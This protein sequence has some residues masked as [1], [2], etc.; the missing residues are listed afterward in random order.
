M[1]GRYAQTTSREALA[2]LLD[3]IPTVE[4][5]PR[6]NISPTQLCPVVVMEEGERRLALQRWGLIPPFAPDEKAT[7][8]MFNAR[9]ETMA[10]KPVF[11]AALQKRR[12]LVPADGWYEWRAA[13]RFKQPFLIRRSDRR[14][15]MFAGVWETWRRPDG[16]ALR[17]FAIATVQAGRDLSE[18][19]ERMPAVLEPEHWDAWLDARVDGGSLALRCLKSAPEGRFEAIA[20]SAR[21][22]QAGNDGPEVQEPLRELDRLEPEPLQPRLI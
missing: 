2:V 10:Q 1:C 12:C 6:Y 5:A 8:P 4:F 14:P 7:P 22:N 17:S 9:A 11:R 16:S 20:V 15:I 18:I 13:G 19:H 3:A 21:V